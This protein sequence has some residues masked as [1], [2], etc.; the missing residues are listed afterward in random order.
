[1][2]IP[3]IFSVKMAG[4]SRASLAVA[5]FVLQVYNIQ[6]SD[7]CSVFCPQNEKICT[8]DDG[9]PKPT[10]D[11]SGFI[12]VDSCGGLI[13]YCSVGGECKPEENGCPPGE[14]KTLMHYFCFGL[15]I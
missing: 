12:A 2:L 8:C 3:L 14:L 6:L 4:W 9:R 13:H 11:P 7:G 1:M 5:L 15:I 10:P